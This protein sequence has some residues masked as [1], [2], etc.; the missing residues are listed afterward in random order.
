MKRGIMGRKHGNVPNITKIISMA[1]VR[2]M[3]MGFP[4]SMFKLSQKCGKA[5]K[6]FRQ[7]WAVPM[8]V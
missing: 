1:N 2:K 6:D 3:T 4:D 5:P 7:F 8:E